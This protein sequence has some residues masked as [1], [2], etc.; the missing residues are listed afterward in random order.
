[1]HKAMSLSKGMRAA[2]ISLPND[3]R[4]NKG[5]KG[6]IFNV[7]K[8]FLILNTLNI[9]LYNTIFF[10]SGRKDYNIFNVVVLLLIMY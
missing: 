7:V 3:K 5:G 8:R 9:S 10:P 6:K 4:G 2:L 1:M